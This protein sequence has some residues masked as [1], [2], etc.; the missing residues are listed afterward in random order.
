[1]L[2]CLQTLSLQES[3]SEENRVFANSKFTAKLQ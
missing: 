2:E 1:M 3:Y